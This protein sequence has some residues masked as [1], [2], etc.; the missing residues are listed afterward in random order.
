MPSPCKQYFTR[1]VGR[2]PLVNQIWLIYKEGRTTPLLNS[3]Y[4]VDADLLVTP[5]KQNIYKVFGDVY[6]A[7]RM[8]APSKIF[9]KGTY[10]TPLEK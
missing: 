5:C 1:G 3:V 2:T 8:Q 7:I 6:K 4:K 10:A 9:Y